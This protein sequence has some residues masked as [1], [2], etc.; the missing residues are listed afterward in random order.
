MASMEMAHLKEIDH[1]DILQLAAVDPSFFASAFFPST[2]KQETPQFHLDAWNALNDPGAALVNLL[3]FRGGAKT[4]LARLFTARRIAYLLSRTIVYVGKSESHA[5]RSIR[6]LKRNIEHNKQF[7]QFY[8]LE[9]AMPWSDLEIRI[10][11]TITGKSIYL[12]GMGVTG[13]LRGIND[14]DNRPDLIVLD[15]LLDEE[16]CATPDQR[17]KIN[18]LI[19]GAV[20]PSLAPQS[21]VQDAKVVSLVTPQNKEDYSMLAMKDKDWTTIRQGV[22]TRD[23]EELELNRRESAWPSRWSSAALR[24]EKQG[25]LARN[26]ASIFAR[27]REI[28]LIAAEDTAF[29]GEWLKYWDTEPDR[30][31]MAISL[32]ID[33]VPPPT[34][35]AL[36]KGLHK[37]DF[38]VLAVVGRERGPKT[39]GKKRYLLDYVMSRGHKPDWTVNQFFRLLLK[40][41]P[42]IATIEVVG[43]QST[44]S[45]LIEQEMERRG[46]YCVLEEEN[47]KGRGSKFNHITEC[48]SGP[49]SNGLW[50]VGKK[51]DQF[52]TDF[53][54]YPDIPYDDLL[55]CV[56]IAD[57]AMSKAYLGEGK[58]EKNGGVTTDMDLV[59]M[60]T[61]LRGMQ[62]DFCP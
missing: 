23:T 5:V 28:K 62:G 11:H 16:N 1:A 12:V 42:D 17:K 29:K 9:K 27:E 15:D 36:A 53:G 40:W 49:A 47:T 2:V 44:L 22:W 26:Q 21:E 38:E 48:F 20:I 52:I 60:D 61:D 50:Y 25:Y 35:I 54:E 4:T 46:I 41:R 7:T 56:A 37:K 51:H 14:D 43:Y 31:N 8:G 55:D 19:Y 39:Q 30:E 6:W 59:P 3:I 57:T 13:S 34:K 45:W 33:P 10:N 18:E 58:S 24:R 32:A